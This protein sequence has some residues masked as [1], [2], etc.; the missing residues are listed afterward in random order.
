M[1]HLDAVGTVC[2]VLVVP[3]A[4]MLSQKRGRMSTK[5][6]AFCKVSNRTLSFCASAC[7]IKHSKHGIMWDC[8]KEN[9]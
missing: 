1:S 8:P 2:N 5:S 3:R 4:Y 7:R 9:C 6:Q